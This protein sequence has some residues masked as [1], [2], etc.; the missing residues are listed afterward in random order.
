MRIITGAPKGTHHAKLYT[1]VG[2]ESLDKR[3][4]KHQ[5]VLYY[6]M[7]NNLAPPYLSL[8]VCIPQHQPHEHNIRSNVN[9]PVW[10]TYTASY[11]NSFLPS[12][13]KVLG[14]LRSSIRQS[15]TLLIFKGK[16]K[17]HVASI[18]K[19]YLT[20]K[21]FNQIVH[22]KMR[23]D[24]QFHLYLG[25]LTE[26]PACRCG[27]TIE[28]PNHFFRTCLLYNNIIRELIFGQCPKNR[29]DSIWL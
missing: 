1:E 7:A 28:G 12:A 19:Y 29:S 24:L 17:A 21:R 6:K 16:L 27:P 9:P 4:K 10:T 11:N 26:D 14:D 18:P 5:L 15:P 25:Y 2:L 20:S 3:R 8:R 22:A 23:M 13:I